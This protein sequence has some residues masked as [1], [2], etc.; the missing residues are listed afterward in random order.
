[1]SERTFIGL[2]VHARSVR[3]ALLDGL[4]GEVRS[5]DAPV[6]TKKLVGWICAQPAPQAVAYEAGPTGY[7][8]ARALDGAGVR[9]VVAAPSRILR[10]SGERVKTDRRDALKLAR[11][12]RLE[13]LVAVRVPTP[14]EEAARDLVRA[15]EDARVDL[16][17]HRHRLAK[18]LLR[19][20]IA[21]EQRAWTGQHELWLARQRFAE[22]PLQLA[23][24]EALQ[25]MRSARDRRDAL[26]R[27]IAEEAAKEPWAAVVARLSCL[28]GVSTLTAFG[29]AV[30]IG[31][32][33]RF[34]GRGLA[35]FLGLTPSE[36]SSGATRHLGAITKTGNGYLRRL[37][38]EAAWQQRRPAGKSARV[39]LARA[40]AP[41]AVRERARLAERRLYRRWMRFD[42]RGKR[43]TV[44][45]VAVARE[46]AG[47]C[48]SL[49]VM[50]S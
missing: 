31:D 47:W 40:S 5:L 28:R 2:D 43:S 16:M 8:L 24:D 20:G 30:E 39:G 11:L 33:Q 37:L 38:I 46:L 50:E 14:T 41:A 12:L 49:A 29:L 3:A 4:T 15:R 45:A 22:A 23:Y 27:A 25:A 17:R 7:V 13:E 32:W 26:D 35:A 10:A 36:D 9:C 6:P 18:L 42:E 1:M 34:S 44:A 48:W 21:W 19:R